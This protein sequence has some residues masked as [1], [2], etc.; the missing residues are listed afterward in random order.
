MQLAKRE[1]YL[2]A[3]AVIIIV[4]A[5]IIQLAVMPFFEK[6]ERY[7]N[8]V[9]TKQNNLQQMVALRQEYLLLQKDSDTLA[10]TLT[11]R[12]KSFTLFSFLEKAAGD[13]GVKNNIKYMKPSASTGTGPFKESLV[14]MKL[15]R[16]TLGQMVGYLKLIESP[17]K[18]VSIKRISIQSN[19]KE[20]Q[21]LDAILQVLTF[22]E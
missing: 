3:L 12:P 1:K 22:T 17:G 7:R 16:I 15:E 4:F 13:A 11:S 21:F 9:T 18:L 14:E 19:K 6:R 20:T 10:Q 2:I 8:N 5:V